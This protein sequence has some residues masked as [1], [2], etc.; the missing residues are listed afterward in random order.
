MKYSSVDFYDDPSAGTLR[1][2][3][4]DLNALPEFI[5]TAERLEPR[6]L[7]GLPD[8]VFAL[9]MLD[10]GEKF[11]KF[12]CVDAG[13]TALSVMY[14]MENRDALPAEAQKTAAAN[15]LEACSWYD[16]APPEELEKIA[17]VGAAMAA[18][19]GG[20]A[21]SEGSS[22]L[23]EAK[24]KLNQKMNAYPGQQPISKTASVLRPHVDVTGQP[25]APRPQAPLPIERYALVK[26]GQAMYP[27]DTPEQVDAA[28]RYFMDIEKRACFDPF[29]R[30]MYCIKVASAADAMGLPVPDMMR[31]YAAPGYAPAGRVKVAVLSRLPYFTEEDRETAALLDMVEKYAGVKPEY[32]AAALERFDRDHDLHFEWDSKIPDPCASTFGI[33]K[34]AEWSSTVKDKTITAAQLSAAAQDKAGLAKVLGKDIAE[35]LAESP[36]ET[37]DSLPTP[38]KQII[39]NRA[40][41]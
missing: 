16:L 26:E 38:H 30:R 41:V 22:S 39:M 28:L 5:K 17:I 24:D 31:D 33:V 23:K 4:P 13:N 7:A 34:K 18:L 36:Q 6:Q 32:F 21:I 37:F 40:G 20:M 11:R 10:G 12:A 8:D 15:L 19:T 27:I 29:D 9:V 25:P 2:R 3:V 35:G 1:A 14:F